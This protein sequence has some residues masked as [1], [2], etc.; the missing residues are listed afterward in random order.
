MSVSSLRLPLSPWITKASS[1]CFRFP[2][3]VFVSRTPPLRPALLHFFSS[4]TAST[5]AF[6]TR[7]APDQLRKWQ[8]FRKKKVVLRIGYVGTDYR[9]LQMQRNQLSHPTIEQELEDAIYKAGGIC[10]SNYGNLNK[11][12]WARSSRTDKGVHSLATTITLK[13]EIPGSAWIDDPCGISLADYINSYLPDNIKVFGIVP[14]QKRFDPR[15]ECDV[16]M[17]SYLLPAK[18]IGIESKLKTTE[19]D[20]HISDFKDILK[21]FEGDHPFH[22]YTVRSIYRTRIRAKQLVYALKSGKKVSPGDMSNSEFEGSDQENDTFVEGIKEPDQRSPSLSVCENLTEVCSKLEDGSELLKGVRAR[23]LHE[24]DEKDRIGASHFRRILYCSCGKL[25][26]YF[27]C[28]F[29]EISIWGESF[30]LHQ[31]R[32]M[33]A[34]AVAV[35]RKLLPRDII[36]LSLTKFSRIVLPI[37]PAEV[38]VLRGNS[39]SNRKRP[40][41]PMRSELFTL[42][43]SD[44]IVNSVNEF[45]RSAILP[46]VTKFLDTESPPWKEWVEKL[47]KYTSI[48]NEELDEVRSAWKAWKYREH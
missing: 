7:C 15:K 46:E 39:F 10:D 9:G 41:A 11:I 31:I 4:S 48:P 25:E 3:P 5:D 28:D 24:P 18:L 14:A 33:I 1:S 23:W 26:T 42:N 35:K 37:A 17:Y 47:D 36:T 40:G 2:D 44:D 20:C 22:N 6:S 30:M 45:Y 43:E 16:R 27:G 8:A 38:L 32:K 21:S 29:I 19:I 34:T 13:M 12:S